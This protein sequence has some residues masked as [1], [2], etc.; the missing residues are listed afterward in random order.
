MPADQQLAVARS[1]Q[2]RPE[3]SG[4]VVVDLHRQRF[5]LAAQPLSRF[6]PYRRE[7]DPLCSVRIAG[8]LP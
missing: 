1:F 5:K 4:C 8:E 3:I 7:C 2:G 6:T